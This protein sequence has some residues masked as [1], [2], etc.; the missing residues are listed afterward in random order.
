MDR[1]VGLGVIGDNLINIGPLW[2]KR[3]RRNKHLAT[4]GFLARRSSPAGFAL[5]GAIDHNAEN[6]N[7]A[8]ESS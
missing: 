8:P 4:I 3:P 7:F 6:L 1:W 2:N 5:P